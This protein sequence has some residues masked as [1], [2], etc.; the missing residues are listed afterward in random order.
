MPNVDLDF[1]DGAVKVDIDKPNNNQRGG[2][3]G[4]GNVTNLN[5]GNTPDITGQN[6]DNGGNKN[7]DGNKPGEGGNVDN[8]GGEG[9]NKPG[10]GEGGNKDNNN[11]SSTGELEPGTQIEFEGANYTVAENGDI[12]DAEGKVFKPAAEV[13]DWMKGLSVE[14]NDGENTGIDMA[15]IQEAV[16]VNVTDEDGKPIEFTNDIAGIKSYIEK[17]ND[18]KAEEIRQGAIN[19][20]YTDNPLLKQ[21][22]DY[23]SVTGTYRGFGELPDR[24]GITIDKDNETQQENII[25]MAA[26]E[27]GNKS[28]SDAYI[29]FL[30]DSGG[31]YDEAVN[32]L[33]S[34]Q[35]HDKE[36]RADIEK[37]AEAQRAK[38]LKDYNDYWKN[39]NDVIA[40]RNIAGCKLP[41]S[42]VKEVNGQKVTL[43]PNDF[44]NYLYRRTVVTENG[45]RI[46]EYQRDLAKISDADY[47]NQELLNAWLMFSG[48]SYK[49]L[50][51]MAVNE[52]EVA[53]LKLKAAE[54]RTAKTIKIVKP[55][56]KS[57]ISDIILT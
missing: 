39:V 40:S 15:A 7:N 50:A 20:L 29:K 42:F 44:Y 2:V 25:R 18:L 19:K 48:G 30:K 26:Q 27:F 12:L 34:L 56:N 13:A 31:L 17:V 16:G 54:R 38:D 4:D 6:N 14:A 35:E 45:D 52:Q 28:V 9:G 41:E 22:S 51:A 57:N 49:D 3:A 53:K 10:E 33:T 47:L 43:T 36:I 32:S 11:N 37:R 21:F 23:V 8:N 24:T 46:S 1:G 55:Q 5:G